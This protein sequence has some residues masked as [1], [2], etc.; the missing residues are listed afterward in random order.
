MQHRFAA[1]ALLAVT[2]LAAVLAM[3]CTEGT[4]PTGAAPSA[5]FDFT[6]GPAEPGRSGL[7]R[8]ADGFLEAV[9][10]ETNRLLSLHGLQNT[11]EDLDCSDPSTA[12]FDLIA[13]QI[14]PHAGDVFNALMK[15]DASTVQIYSW[16]DLDAFGCLAEPIYRGTVSFVRTDNN[17]GGTTGQR[18]NSWGW[19]AQ[20]ELTDLVNG[21]TVQYN[22]VARFMISPDD[23]FR[24]VVATIKIH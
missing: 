5:S 4:A 18:A 2:P 15:A 9:D 23:E 7:Y 19:T 6:N 24:V 16:D 21:G 10:D 14:R 1:R 13:Q 20:G 22:E 12:E 8:T 11:L 3:S 17:L